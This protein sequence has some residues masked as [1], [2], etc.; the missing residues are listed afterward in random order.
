MIL[1][2]FVVDRS[3]RMRLDA[4]AVNVETSVIEHVETVTGSAE[5][6]ISMVGILAGK[7][8][9]GLKLPGRPAP[10]SN[11]GQAWSAA[12]RS[13]A[14]GAPK[15]AGNPLDAVRI[16]AR[17]L[18]EDDAKNAVAAVALYRQFLS[19]TPVTFATSYRQKA[20]ARLKVLSGGID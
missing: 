20:E 8:N 11:D 4:R 5:D 7:L 19:E 15:P 3:G 13:I 16:Y 2:G 10:P 6:V 9:G 12:V 17:A 1:G 18:V 14:V